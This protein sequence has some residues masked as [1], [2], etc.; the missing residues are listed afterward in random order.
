[1]P[2]NIIEQCYKKSIELLKN[3]STDLGILASA[4][5]PRAIKRNYLSVFSRDASVCV[6]GMVL[7]GDKELIKTAKN[8]LITLSKYQTSNGQ[9]PNNVIDKSHHA[10]FWHMGCIDATLWWLIAL[11]V[12]DKN[13]GDKRLLKS[14]NK[15][16]KHAINWLQCREHQG[17]GLLMQGEASDWADIFPRSGKVLYSNAIWVKVKE[18]YKIKDYKETKKSFHNLFYPYN[19]KMKEIPGCNRPSL[20]KI[21]KKQK[22][23]QFYLSFVNYLYWG[24][25]ID[26]FGN[27]LAV[28][29]GDMDKKLAKE[30]LLEISKRKNK[31]DFPAPVLLNPIKKG[32][33]MWRDYMMIMKQNEPYQY[34]NGG[35]W[36]FVSAFF[37]IALYKIGEKDLAWE[38][39]EKVAYANKI[40]NWQ[41]NEWFYGLT[42][43]PMGMKKQSWNAGM[44]LAAYH[45]LKK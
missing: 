23:Q 36:P 12:Y 28:I 18:M 6:L 16:V 40:N 33:K 27:S 45:H 43:E 20:R 29:F 42:G 21:R 15:K 25:D 11:K 41:F 7:S 13:S 8:S 38:E 44:F 34:H 31:K 22:D 35:I 3:N 4:S 19:V 39:L 14:L 9:I 5:S 1:M 17:D 37:A 32:D 10:Y 30:I 26:V 24:E 2:Q